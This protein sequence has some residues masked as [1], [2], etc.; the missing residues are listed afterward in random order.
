[1]PSS[2][3]VILP[4][5]SKRRTLTKKPA[6][7]LAKKASTLKSKEVKKVKHEPEAT[8]KAGRKRKLSATE[9]NGAISQIPKKHRAFK[10]IHTYEDFISTIPGDRVLTCGEGEQLGHPGRTTTKKPRAIGTLPEDSK[11]LQVAAGGVHTAILTDKHEVYSCGINEGGTVP[12][13]DLAAEET[14]D[15]LTVIEFDN[16]VKKEGNIIQL[17]AGAGF[18]AALTDLGSVIAWG[19]LRVSFISAMPYVYLYIKF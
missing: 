12:V 6:T 7:S 3:K 19:N 9:Q 11:V 8:T 16:E 5:Q 1:M 15:E 13:K 4:P 14:K 10:D 18:T 17:T 2:I